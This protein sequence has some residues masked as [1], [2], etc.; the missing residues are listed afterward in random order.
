MLKILRLEET[1]GDNETILKKL[2]ERT[3]EIEEY[4]MQIDKL[5]QTNMELQ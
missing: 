3:N 1:N 5:M 4:N 2:R